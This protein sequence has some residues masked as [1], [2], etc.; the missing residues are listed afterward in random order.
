MSDYSRTLPP[1]RADIVGSF[2]RP[3]ALKE[4]RR[5][6]E[7][8]SLSPE[9]LREAEDREIR[10]LV[11]RERAEGLQSVTDGEF[12]RSWWHLDFMW[13]LDGVEKK[14][15]ESGYHFNS[16]DTRAESIRLTGKLHFGDHPFLHH[17]AFLNSIADGAVARQ[18]IPS[19]A[20]LWAELY[21]DGNR[22]ETE[23][24]YPDAEELKHD[25]VQ[26]YR[27]AIQA[28]Y[29]AGCR[30]L[31]MDD[32][33]WGMLVD[34]DFRAIMQKA[35]G[36]PDEA[37]K[38]YAELDHLVLQGRPADMAV[39]MH[40]CRGNYHSA[41]AG[42][43]G[44]EPVAETLFG[45]VD[46]DAFYLEYDSDRAG[47]FEPLRFIRGQMVVLGLVTTKSPVP[48]SEETLVRRVKEAEKYLPLDR[49]CLSPQCGFAS[50]EEG[51]LLTE[52]DQWNKIRLVRKTAE[53]IWK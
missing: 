24:V 19:P 30:N 34:P 26:V 14:Q 36:S 1:F 13:G 38:L 47:G 45:T 53:E 25:L 51:N 31:Q 40:I 12:R 9:G 23:A 4:A 49:L 6:R 28:F 18:T 7:A 5:Q 52:E 37:A 27:D 2:L 15:V 48:E 3:E 42:A 8:G 32:C 39:N 33:T 29:R 11:A 22:A 41:W 17:F 20:Q 21:R 16:M 44:Y 50:T 46:V 10:K 35:G 43:G